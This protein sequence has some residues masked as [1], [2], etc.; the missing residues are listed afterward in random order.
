MSFVGWRLTSRSDNVLL[1]ITTTEQHSKQGATNASAA[2]LW[3]RACAPPGSRH[4]M[5]P[6]LTLL[7]RLGNKPVDSKHCTARHQPEGMQV[8][9]DEKKR[10]E[11]GQRPDSAKTLARICA[12]LRSHAHPSRAM[13]LTAISVCGQ[14][15]SAFKLKVAAQRIGHQIEIEDDTVIIKIRKTLGLRVMCAG[16]PGSLGS[17]ATTDS[18]RDIHR[19]T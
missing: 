1:H 11:S 10:S 2:L 19:D 9:E 12:G 5:C 6:T 8:G 3:T 15:G 13:I 17:P 7:I 14:L 16:R 4:V 18:R